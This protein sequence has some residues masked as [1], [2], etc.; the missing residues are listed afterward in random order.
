MKARFVGTRKVIKMSTE[1]RRKHFLP[2]ETSDD[3]VGSADPIL[4]EGRE[5]GPRSTRAAK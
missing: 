3:A 1:R 5:T 4:Y 2:N